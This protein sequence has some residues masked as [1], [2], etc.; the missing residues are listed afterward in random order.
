[1]LLFCFSSFVRS[2]V[3]VIFVFDLNENYL[4]IKWKHFHSLES[5]S[6]FCMLI[7]SQI[8]FSIMNFN[9]KFFLYDCE[10][11]H[12]LIYVRKQNLSIKW[13]FS[14][15][16]DFLNFNRTKN[17]WKSQ[18]SHKLRG[19]KG[20]FFLNYHFHHFKILFMNFEFQGI[21]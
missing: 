17:D 6:G 8:Q 1:M 18:N 11:N 2:F 19:I 21:T 9:F 13:N 3:V 4:L 10:S 16:F 15:F 7:F 20:F 12:R 14:K 5:L